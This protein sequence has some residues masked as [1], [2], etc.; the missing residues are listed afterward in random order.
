[1]RAKLSPQSP[2]FVD[3]THKFDN[4]FKVFAYM[5]FARSHSL[6]W[7][8][9]NLQVLASGS[10]RSRFHISAVKVHNTRIDKRRSM[11]EINSS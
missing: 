3:A 9:V 1:M 7:L 8:P 5:Q 11:T 6:Q 2:H 4:M 10:N